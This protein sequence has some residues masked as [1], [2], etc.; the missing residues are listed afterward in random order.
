MRK[1]SDTQ[2]EMMDSRPGWGKSPTGSLS[3]CY[4]LLGGRT[5]GFVNYVGGEL[6]AFRR[7]EGHMWYCVDDLSDAV[8]WVETGSARFE[9]RRD[10]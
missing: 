3:W 6:M 2:I 8:G 1:L 7:G 10:S 4:E 5:N 9:G